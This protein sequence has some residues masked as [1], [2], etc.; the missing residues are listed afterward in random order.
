[1]WINY[2]FIK[3]CKEA[4]KYISVIVKWNYLE[5]VCQLKIIIP[6][7]LVKQTLSLETFLYLNTP[8][9]L[10]KFQALHQVFITK[11]SQHYKFS[12]I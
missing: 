1:M 5:N 7:E 3:N 6:I 4:Q 12:S 2:I 9:S 8:A 10:L 11:L